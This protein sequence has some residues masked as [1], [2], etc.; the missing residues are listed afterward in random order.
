VGSL[1]RHEL[2]I[3]ADLLAGHTDTPASCWFAVWDG[4]GQLH[5]SPAVARLVSG[6]ERTEPVAGLAPPDVL[7]GPR[8]ELPNR[9]YVLLHGAVAEA[10]GVFDLLGRQSRTCGGRTIG[11]GA[12]RPRSTSAGATSPEPA[13]RSRMSLLPPTSR[14]SRPGSPTE[15]LTR[16]TAST[17]PSTTRELLNGATGS[18]LRRP[19]SHRLGCVSSAGKVE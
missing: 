2:R 15:S 13:R 8:L 4:Y 7:S 9:A 10:A 1:P 19:R 6:S 3:V 12:W 11:R 17:P 18:L 16:A 5:G 14:R